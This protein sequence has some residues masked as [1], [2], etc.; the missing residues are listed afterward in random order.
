MEDL[1]DFV[2]AIKAAGMDEVLNKE[3]DLTVFG[4]RDAYV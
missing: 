2:D 4:K 1:S 3:E